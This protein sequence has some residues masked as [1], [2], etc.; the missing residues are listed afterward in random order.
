MSVNE[1]VEL[2][3]ESTW[4]KPGSL[5]EYITGLCL[6]RTIGEVNRLRETA[7]NARAFFGASLVWNSIWGADGKFNPDINSIKQ[8]IERIDGTVPDKTKRDGYANLIGDAI[9]DVFEYESVDQMVI[10]P[11]DITIIALAKVI[12]KVST[13]DCGNNYQKKKDRQTAIDIIL[14]R[15]GGKRSEPVKEVASIEYVEPDWMALPKGE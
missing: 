6:N 3:R 10:Y 12:I 2:A 13:M 9:E 5:D 8:I 15:T 1:S 4:S 11:D 7:T 14:K